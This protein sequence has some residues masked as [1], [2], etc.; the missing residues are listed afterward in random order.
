MAKSWEQICRER[1]HVPP[2][3]SIK[4]KKELI[5]EIGEEKFAKECVRVS[6]KRAEEWMSK[7]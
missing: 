6:L 1:G 4:D 2:E 7:Q 3:Q 5:A